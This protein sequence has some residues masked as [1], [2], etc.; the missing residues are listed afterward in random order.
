MNKF[1]VLG[2]SLCSI[3]T[4]SACNQE[5]SSA[6]PA[7]QTTQST[8]GQTTTT[9]NTTTDL[10]K[11]TEAY[12]AWV[13]TQMDGLVS[14]TEKFVAL[15]NDGKVEEAKALYPH[16]RMYF[17]RS[18]PVAELFGDLDPRIDNREADLQAGETWTGYHAIEK[19]LWTK[20]TTDGTQAL[21]EKLLADVKE[22][23]AKTPT[24]DVTGDLMVQGSVDLLNEISTSKITGEEEVFSHTDLY[25]FWANIEGA[26]KIFEILSP[27]IAEKDPTLVKTIREK[28]DAVY[29]LLNQHKIGDKDFKSYQELS[30]A[31]TKALADAINQLGEP[32]AQMGIILK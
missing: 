3:M 29:K 24:A 31:D 32:L 28:F 8:Q 15:L 1:T 22:L 5:Q 25:D 30:E 21:G 14:E 2:L 12:K 13:S 9:P 11:E 16:A 7:E 10:S 17:E 26:D 19:I 27:K 23:Q 4:L 18:E 6:K 20:N